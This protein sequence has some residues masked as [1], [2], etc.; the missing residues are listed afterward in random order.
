MR[1]SNRSFLIAGLAL[2]LAT[3]GARAAPDGPTQFVAIDQGIDKATLQR[4]HHTD[5]GT[6]FGPA[7]WLAAVERADGSGKF[8]GT[9]NLRRLGWIVDNV[10]VDALNPYGWPVGFT[11]S[12][13]KFAG[14]MPR[15]G[16]TCAACHTGQ[17]NYK[18]TAIR[19]EGGAGIHD[20]PNFLVGLSNAFTATA[21]DPARR[22]RF[23]A[24]AVKAGY[25]AERID[26]D[27]KA[28][29]AGFPG[30][31][32]DP[33]AK[34][35]AEGPGRQDA[36]QG[37]GNRVFGTDLKVPANLK[38]RTAP[39]NAPHV[40]DIW[41]FSWVQWNG[42]GPGDK[43]LGRNIGEVLGTFGLTNIVDAR[44]GKLNPESVRWKSSVQLDAL[45]WMEQTLHSLRAPTWPAEVLG[46]IDAKKAAAGK[47]LFT[48]LCAGCHGIK[49]LPNGVWDVASVSLQTIGT[50]PNAATNWAKDTY[51]ASKL[52]LSKKILSFEGSPIVIN[53]IRK[54]LYAENKTPLAEQEGDLAHEAPCGYKAR[55]LIGIWATPPFLHNGSVRTIFDL[56]SDTRPAKF[57]VG[58]REFDPVNLGYVEGPSLNPFILDTSITGNSNA[59][60]WWTDD[61]SRPGR[62]G[63]KLSDAEKYELIEYLKAATYE[64]YPSEKRAK[65]DALSCKGDRYWAQKK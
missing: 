56:L 19:V 29:V 28:A 43:P 46:P 35:T 30:L 42:F 18:G 62:I 44:T 34:S 39:V 32:D 63:A 65:P 20:L 47:E 11:V 15:A 53:A 54:Q 36:V 16:V 1:C 25:P 51:D 31:A 3:F 22:A 37:I 64:N 24:D 13:P 41:R 55:P 5:Q 38:A 58:S 50:D 27:F 33:L 4:Y 10:S 48:G 60:H 57:I 17:I 21:K 26:A 45:V 49:V 12:K 23:Y 8:M 6:R 14:D 2:S 9:D 40:W 59:G 61:A 52:G 7:A